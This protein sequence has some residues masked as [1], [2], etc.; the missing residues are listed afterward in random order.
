MMVESRQPG[1]LGACRAFASDLL[2]CAPVSSK[3]LSPA[4]VEVTDMQD[5]ANSNAPTTASFALQSAPERGRYDIAIVG[6][7]IIGLATA[8][9]LLLRKPA[10]RV[11]VVEKD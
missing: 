3:R 11:I 10:L 4:H 5:A 8:R 7:G 1:M 6:G 2:S 9:E